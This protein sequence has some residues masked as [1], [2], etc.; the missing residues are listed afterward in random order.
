[1]SKEIEKLIAAKDWKDARKLIRAALRKKPDSHWLLTRLGLTYY[2]EYN[3]EK[4][5]FYSGQALELAPNCPLVM[6]CANGSGKSLAKGSTRS[7]SGTGLPKINSDEWKSCWPAARQ[8][9]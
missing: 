3:Y 6:K 8:A 5:L 2:E 1:M 4:A 9:I 7:V